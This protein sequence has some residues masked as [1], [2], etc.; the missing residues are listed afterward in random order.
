MHVV[1]ISIVL[2]GLWYNEN[3]RDPI[4]T[5]HVLVAPHAHFFFKNGT[6]YKDGGIA[7]I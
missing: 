1:V 4:F 6:K 3:K 7:A 5:L 2:R